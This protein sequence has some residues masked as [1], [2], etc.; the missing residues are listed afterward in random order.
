MVS[1]EEPTEA[2]EP[3][4]T[5]A[6]RAEGHGDRA[7]REKRDGRTGPGDGASRGARAGLGG[8]G[9]PH[10]AAGAR[11]IP[12][13]RPAVVDSAEAQVEAGDAADDGRT[14]ASSAR[15][16][17]VP[18]RATLRP[19]APE[20]P[21]PSR[22]SPADRSPARPAAQA[23]SP[24]AAPSPAHPAAKEPLWRDV[25]GDVLRRERLSQERTLKDVAEAARISMP[26]LSELER[27]RKEASS[28]VLAAA[29]RALGLTLTDLLAR[30]HAEIIRLTGAEPL[31]AR[32]ALG[33]RTL[34]TGSLTGAGVRPSSRRAGITSGAHQSQ[35]RLAA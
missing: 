22:L 29:A 35:L 34:S 31:G 8:A 18:Q 30:G 1:S 16:Q 23:P 21:A 28:E 26:Y 25:V 7:G 15:P 20:S 13:R 19:A 32:S 11:V 24:A 2:G 27:G 5:R 10:L 3:R 14:V 4:D 17:A 6:T 9:A 12:L 33:A